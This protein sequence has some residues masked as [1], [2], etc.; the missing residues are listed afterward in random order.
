MLHLA[1][2][3]KKKQNQK[4]NLIFVIISAFKTLKTDRGGQ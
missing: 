3:V 4:G 2:L 1:E